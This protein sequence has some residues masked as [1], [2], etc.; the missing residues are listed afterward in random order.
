MIQIA[1]RQMVY[2]VIKELA[3]IAENVII[4]TQSLSKDVNQKSDV[5]YRAN[6]IRVLCKI[7]DVGTPFSYHNASR[8]YTDSAI[9]SCMLQGIERFLKQAIVDKNPSVSSAALVS[10]LH[11]FSGNK[12]AVKRWANEVQ[13][14]INSKGMI[15]QYHALGLMY[16]IRQ[17]DRMAVIKLVQNYSRGALRSPLAHCMLIRYACKIMDEE[18]P[19]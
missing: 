6:A 3:N 16:Q 12:E 1:L 8:T 19:R 7:T 2:L 11:L 14:A 13:E 5:I 17:H 4:V 9:Q 10:A 15:T 18:D